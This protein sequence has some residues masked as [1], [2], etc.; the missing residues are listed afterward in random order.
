MPKSFDPP[1]TPARKYASGRVFLNALPLLYKPEASF[2]RAEAWAR[3][4]NLNDAFNL[5]KIGL[6]VP[7]GARCRSKDLYWNMCLWLADA[8]F[9]TEAEQ[10][11]DDLQRHYSTKKFSQS[12]KLHFWTRYA[13]LDPRILEEMKRYTARGGPKNLI[14]SALRYLYIFDLSG[15]ELD[16]AYLTHLNRRRPKE[17][18]WQNLA[19]DYLSVF[20]DPKTQSRAFKKIASGLMA[21]FATTSLAL[22][23]ALVQGTI[24]ADARNYDLGRAARF[25]ELFDRGEAEIWQMLSDGDKSIAIVGNSAE[26]IGLGSGDQI[27]GFDIVMRFNVP[28]GNKKHAADFGSK[29]D[30]HI[31][32][33]AMLSAGKAK[34]LADVD[35]LITGPDWEKFSHLKTSAEQ[36]LG[37]GCRI[38]LIPKEV[39]ADLV[40]NLLAT[41]SSGI[42]V[43]EAVLRA[44]S[45]TDNVKFFGFAF[46][47]QVGT[48][49]NSANYFRKSRPSARHNWLGE[50]EVFKS[51][52]AKAGIPKLTAEQTRKTR[53]SNFVGTRNS[54]RPL[55]FRLL[56]DHSRYHCGSWAVTRHILTSMSRFGLFVKDDDYDIL[57]MN[58]EGSMHHDSVAYVKKMAQMRE[59]VDAGKQVFLVNSVWQENS[60][61]DLDLLRQLDKIY[62][63][64]V[65]SRNELLEKHGIES[66]LYPDLSFRCALSKP[67]K[68]RNFAG[69]IVLTD[70]YSKEFKTF[71]RWTGAEGLKYPY[72]DMKKTKWPDMVASLKTAEML[73]TGRHHAVYA[74]CRAEVPFIA[75]AGNTHKIDGL[76]KAADVKI[77]MAQNREELPELIDWVRQNNAE[78]QKLF[79]WLKS[80]P[81]W[82]PFT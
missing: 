74:A 53:Y 30:V 45:R 38:G 17:A 34:Q 26:A 79:S 60:N 71:A 5:L 7:S 32:N 66:T 35:I 68:K 40:R 41:P 1:N 56:G 20:S 50:A 11:L 51:V 14:L 80:F 57:I 25:T 72:I 27:D 23:R 77:P 2:R 67:R 4:G 63:R 75:F 65:S 49:P 70:F 15:P 37:Q 61:V 13:L 62:V 21:D 48:D 76:L 82:N 43:C 59:A 73:V 39:R 10:R 81:A 54:F 9:L 64:E 29:T 52:V 44:R 18:F 3:E 33:Q 24:K 69:K 28:D 19:L 78:Y 12:K 36:L 16:Q 46:S 6:R 47:D 31:I 8:G 55:R 58:G 42:Q 22:D